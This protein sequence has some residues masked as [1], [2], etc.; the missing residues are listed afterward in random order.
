MIHDRLDGLR[1]YP[2]G[3][4]VVMHPHYD[5]HQPLPA[6]RHNDASPDRRHHAIDRVG[7]RPVER[8][9]KRD[10]TEGSHILHGIAPAAPV[11]PCSV[12]TRPR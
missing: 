4:R 6:E 1:L 11:Y 9:R 3:Q 5:A 10:I 8:N 2:L 7:K 12:E